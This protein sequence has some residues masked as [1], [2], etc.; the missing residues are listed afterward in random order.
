MV[1][2]RR[3]LLAGATGCL[4]IGLT[5][6]SAHATTT[7][8]LALRPFYVDPNTTAA[9]ATKQYPADAAALHVIASTAQARWVGDWTT[10]V[11]ADVNTYVSAATAAKQ[12]PVLA[13]YAIP[14]RDLGSY[15]AGGLSGPAAYAAWIDKVKAG[16]RGRPCAVIVEPDAVPQGFQLSGS[17]QSDRVAMLRHAVNTLGVSST[18]YLDGGHSRWLK[19][20]DLVTALKFIGGPLR[21]FSLN[22]SGFLTTAEEVA[23]GD[24]VAAQTGLSYVVDTSRNGLGPPSAAPLN[25]C[26]PAGRSLGAKPSAST[27]STHCD[28]YLWVKHPGESDGDCHTGDPYSGHWWN[29]YALGLVQRSK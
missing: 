1:L 24:E 18:V 3:T 7:N 19:V 22:V 13:L 6:L 26:N 4:A 23:Y 8:P 10:D 17:A 14:G 2:S 5:P 9:L 16:I 12:M 28:A 11:Q 21:G 29:D 15:S 27:A 25:W 20:A